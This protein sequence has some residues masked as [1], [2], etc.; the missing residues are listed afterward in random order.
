M[1]NVYACLQPGW[2]DW[3]AAYVLSGLRRHFGR[4]VQVATPDGGPVQSIGGLTVKA[5]LRFADIC[6][7]NGEFLI[8]IDSDAWTTVA[9]E[10]IAEV[11]RASYA[12]NAVI[13]RICA[14]TIAIARAGLLVN[15]AHTSNNRSFLAEYAPGYAGSDCYVDSQISVVDGSIVTAPGLAPLSF[16]RDVFKLA[17][18][19]KPDD[20]DRYFEAYSR[21]VHMTQGRQ[22]G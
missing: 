17:N 12:A 11:L 3:E 9:T 2:A 6:A 22:W 8:L 14:A 7:S 1:K 20:A 4:N 5:D 18:P 15:R 19:N 16:A 13:A 10:P 21:E